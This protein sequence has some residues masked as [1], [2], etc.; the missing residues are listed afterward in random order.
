MRRSYAEPNATWAT[1]VMGTINM[2]EALRRLEAPC[3]AVLIN[4]DHVWRNK[5]WLYG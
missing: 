5:E 1:H 2:L 4:T 3:A